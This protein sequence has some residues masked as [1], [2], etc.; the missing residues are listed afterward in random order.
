MYI[1]RAGYMC[2]NLMRLLCSF[3]CFLVYIGLL[4]L[5]ATTLKFLV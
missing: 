1:E 4:I 5:Q 2:Y 3:H